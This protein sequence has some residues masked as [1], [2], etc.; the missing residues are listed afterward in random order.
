[1]KRRGGTLRHLQQLIHEKAMFAPIWEDRRPQRRR[2]ASGGL[3]ARTHRRLPILGPVRACQAQ[4]QVRLALRYYSWPRTGCR[5][6][7]PSQTRGEVVMPVYEH[8]CD[9][10]DREVQLP[11]SIPAHA[12]APTP[13][14]LD[15]TATPPPT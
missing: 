5:R 9:N 15:P 2:P 8:S 13:P 11:L 12:K 4:G 6:V 3:R 7:N 1:T 14:S 10:G